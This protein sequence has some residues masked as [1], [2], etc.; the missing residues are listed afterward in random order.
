MFVGICEGTAMN[1]SD[2]RTR[3]DALT[4]RSCL[5]TRSAEA[6]TRRADRE[7]T[8]VL[9]LVDTAERNE[10]EMPD[11]LIQAL[12]ELPDPL[13]QALVKKLPKTGT[14]KIQ[15]YVLR[16]NRAAISKQ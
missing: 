1:I 12:D 8:P 14:G 13:I 10:A 5:V 4:D 3:V 6:E 7:E 11:P 16:G 9:T 15:K 2:I